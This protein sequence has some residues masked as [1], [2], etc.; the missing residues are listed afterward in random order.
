[1]SSTAADADVDLEEVQNTLMNKVV[2]LTSIE[3]IRCTFYVFFA[4]NFL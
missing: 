3:A 4:K 1:L 2:E